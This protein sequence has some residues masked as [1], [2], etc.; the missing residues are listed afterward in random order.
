MGT[1]YEARHTGTGRRVAL[2]LILGDLARNPKLLARFELE[3]RVAGTIE[4]EHI[5]HV[6]DVGRDEERDAPF[7]AM[8]YLVGEDLDTLFARLGPVD[9]DLALRIG[10]QA[11]LGLEKAHAL[12]IVHRDLKPANLF[13]TERDGGELR[14]KILDFGVAK[15]KL[16]ETFGA[17][18]PKLTRTG[19]LVG[20]PIYMSPEQA[21]GNGKVDHR[22]DL[23]SLA[24]V[25]YEALAGRQPFEDIDGLGQ[26]IIAICTEPTEPIRSYAPWVDPAIA[27]VVE[28]A[29]VL[30]PAQRWQSAG[31]MREALAALLPQ[32][33]TIRSS[34]LLSAPGGATPATAAQRD[35]ASPGPPPRAP[36]LGMNTMTV[37]GLIIAASA[38]AIAKDGAHSI[39]GTMVRTI[40][41]TVPGAPLDAYV[42]TPPA[43]MAPA[44]P[45][46][47]RMAVLAG[48]LLLGATSLGV[49]GAYSLGWIAVKEPAKVSVKSSPPPPTIAPTGSGSEAP[50]PAGPLSSLQGVWR[51]DSGRV[52]D[53]VTAGDTLEFRIRD[54]EQLAGQGY[55]RGEA[56]FVLLRPAGPKGPFGVEDH[57]RPLPPSGMSYDAAR[58]GPSCV[59]IWSEV[60]GKPLEARIED[61]RLLVRMALVEAAATMFVREGIGVVGCK[62]LAR[63]RVSVVESVLVRQSTR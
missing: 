62:D 5:V 28:R 55:A 3:A 46:P 19:A 49:V 57:V 34:M 56:R 41:A 11:C 63:A 45:S 8:E 14:V 54:P 18:A 30:D 25:L 37:P 27:K 32:G 59:G 36:A 10:V 44:A 52:Y 15:V 23:W 53:A 6:T 43:V 33:Y 26:L 2:K 50:A 35:A 17:S 58:A 31:E 13:L 4:S 60:A 22:S 1:V 24:V 12:D 61:D 48:A 40:K 39:P 47:A 29:L 51:S 7:L 16:E 42:A 9:P 38:P 20:S 21:R